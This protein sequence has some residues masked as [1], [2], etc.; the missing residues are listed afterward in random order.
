MT[1]LSVEEALDA[2]IL[3]SIVSG[4]EPDI[5]E[6]QKFAK[7]LNDEGSQEWA[8]QAIAVAKEEVKK[9]GRPKKEPELQYEHKAAI[10]D[11]NLNEINTWRAVISIRVSHEF[12]ELEPAQLINIVDQ[13]LDVGANYK[14]G[15]QLRANQRG[16]TNKSHSDVQILI[17]DC[18]KAWE[19]TTGEALTIWQATSKS[20][21]N[22][23][24]IL[25]APA[26]KL[27]RII[28]KVVDGRELNT[29]LRRQAKKSC[30]ISRM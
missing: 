8:H 24:G 20:P 28:A 6:L 22:K 30:N 29:D 11:L 10:A 14:Y 27:A 15:A 26:A 25:E 21:H 9:R 23:S 19:K 18:A 16:K 5:K 7:A 3:E 1:G 13:L 4:K 2:Y 17:Y 12:P